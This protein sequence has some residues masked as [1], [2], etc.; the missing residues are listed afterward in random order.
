M[1]NFVIAPAPIIGLPVQGI[2][3]IFPVRRIYCVGKNYEKHVAE[4]GG[5]PAKSTPVFFTKSREA[6]VQNGSK[7]PYPPQTKNLHFEVELVI[8]MKSAAAIFGYGVGIDMTRR[9]LQAAAKKNGAPWD[10]AK[11]FDCSAPCSALVQADDIVNLDNA[12]IQLS[13]NGDVMQSS[14]LDKMIYSVPDIIGHLNKTVSLRGGDLI[15]T[16]TPEGVGPVNKGDTIT[17]SIQGLP[18]ITVQYI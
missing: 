16:G 8:A 3:D 15:M 7:I 1:N 14:S 10:M 12:S 5:N 18:E 2:G 4:M 11:N 6:V 9:D 13:K 17:G